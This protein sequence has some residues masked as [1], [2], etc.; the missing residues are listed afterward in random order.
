MRNKELMFKLLE[1][2]DGIKVNLRRIVQTNQP[3]ED[4]RA[5]LDKMEEIIEQ[6]KSMVE[7]EPGY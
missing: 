5:E 2:L 7:L 3:I 4:Y 1:R 6:I